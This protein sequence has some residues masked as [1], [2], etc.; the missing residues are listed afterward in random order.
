MGLD[1][2]TYLPHEAKWNCRYSRLVCF[3]PYFHDFFIRN[4]RDSTESFYLRLHG[5]NKM[6]YGS[7]DTRLGITA[8][9]TRCVGLARGQLVRIAGGCLQG[10]TGKVVERQPNGTWIVCVNRGVFVEVQQYLLEVL[11]DS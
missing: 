8:S 4:G 1:N 3:S 2:A 7:S 10:V 6:K 11:K 5:L 9:E